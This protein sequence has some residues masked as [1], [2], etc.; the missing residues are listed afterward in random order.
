MTASK[1]SVKSRGPSTMSRHRRRYGRPSD[2]RYSNMGS[3]NQLT[4]PLDACAEGNHL[5]ILHLFPGL[6]R[7]YIARVCVVRRVAMTREMLHATRDAGILQTLQ[8]VGN[9]WSGNGRVVAEG[10]RTNDDIVRIGVHVSHGSKVDVKAVVLQ[11]GTDG[12]ATL[13]GVLRVASSTDSSHRLVHVLL[14][15]QCRATDCPSA[16]ALAR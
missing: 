9:H 12:V 4:A 15:R 6:Q 11:V 7:L 8:I 1:A 16:N 10:T 13:V 3:H 5:T 2:I 14:L